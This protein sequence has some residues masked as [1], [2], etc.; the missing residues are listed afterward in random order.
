[1][2]IKDDL[3]EPY[4][5]KVD[6]K[7]YHIMEMTEQVAGVKKESELFFSPNLNEV[8]MDLRKRQTAIST[9]TMTLKEF[10]EYESSRLTA[11]REALNIEDDE[12]QVKP[13]VSN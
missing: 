7:G 4:F 9:E 12:K 2:I 10:T 3:L 13:K 1:M 8:F 11:L 6:Y 5:I